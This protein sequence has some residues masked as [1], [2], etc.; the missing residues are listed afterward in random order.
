VHP[1]LEVAEFLT[2]RGFPGVPHVRG[3]LTYR[4]PEG[5]RTL[6][7]L[8]D[9]VPHETDGWNLTLDELGRFSERVLTTRPALPPIAGPLGD[10]SARELPPEVRTI[11][12]PFLPH[13]ELLGRRTGELHRALASDATDPRF[14]PEPFSA[15]YQRALVQSLRNVARQV[16]SRLRRQ[17]RQLP[18]DVQPDVQRVLQMEAEILA[19]ARSAFQDR[20]T[21]RR[22]RYH[23]NYHLGRVL[24]TGKDFVILLFEG[25]P[26]RALGERRIKRSPL[27][28]VASMMRSFHYVS[29]H[30]LSGRV[31]SGAV[32]REDLPILEPAVQSWRHW[33]STA[34]L[35]S[36]LRTIADASFCP[37]TAGELRS[38]LTAYLLEKTF[39]EIAYEMA[40]RPE[41]VH[42]PLR[43]LLDLVER[44]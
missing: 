8:Q 15:L 39:Y 3:A 18:E 1:D 36:Y 20:F 19:R 30:A 16:L 35:Q 27:R 14:A 5:A 26:A 11:L 23:G 9:Y 33:V 12:G 2:E 25:E 43:E 10:L 37:A 22:I 4:A 21:S 6:G 38:A 41:W 13:V 24:F 31:T 29:A 40:Q 42:I 34:F 28:D 17:V 44:R 7:V 32:R